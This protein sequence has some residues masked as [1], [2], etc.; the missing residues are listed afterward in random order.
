MGGDA[1]DCAFSVHPVLSSSLAGTFCIFSGR[2]L[3]VCA[4]LCVAPQGGPCPGPANSMSG[5]K[6]DLEL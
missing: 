1:E 5:A 2:L 6:G 4:S 3:G